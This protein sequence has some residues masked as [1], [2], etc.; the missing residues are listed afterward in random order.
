MALQYIKA[1][2][3]YYSSAVWEELTASHLTASTFGKLQGKLLTTAK[4][5][6]LK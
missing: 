6:G 3:G 1:E 5:L 2:T 4:Y